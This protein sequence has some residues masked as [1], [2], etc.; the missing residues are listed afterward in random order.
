M[1][2]DNKHILQNTFSLN[3]HS[4]RSIAIITDI[5]LCLI[6]TWFAFFVRLEDY[7]LISNYN[8]NKAVIISLVAIPIFWVSGVYRT[9]FRYAGLSILFTITLST[10][11]YGVVYF[12][13]ITIYEIKG[14]PRIIGILQPI[15]F[16]LLIVASR[17]TAKFLLTGTF[18][19]LGNIKN[20]ENILIY[21][22]GDI[23]R[24]L[25]ISLE[26]N[27]QYKVVGFLDDN[28]Q[29]HRQ[30]LLG[31]KIYD[32]NKIENLK[33]NKNINLILFAIPSINRSKKNEIIKNLL[34][35]QLVVKT[36][37]YLNDIIDGKVSVSD[38]KDFLV[39]DLLFRDQIEPDQD[40]LNKNIKSK[41]VLVTGAGGTIGAELCR[42]II[43]L[44]PKILILLEFNEFAL[45]KI[46]DELISINKNLKIIPLLS[47]VQDQ[48]K[49][50][51]IFQTFKVDTIYHT[52]A[53]KHV[54]LVEAN[55]CEG[56]K[57]NVFGTLAVAKASINQK[58]KNLVLISS[59]KAV[60]PT[61][62][63][64]ASKRFAEL[65]MQGLH[66]MNK[67][68]GTSFSIVRFGN[69]I[70]SSGSAIPKF[71]K[72]IK[73]GGPIT[74]THP[75]VTRYFMTVTE[76]AQLVIQA[77]AMSDDCE[78]FILDMGESVKIKNLINKMIVLSGL[79]VKDDKNLDGDI[80][81]NVTG[82]RP[83]EKLY[84][85]LL[86]GDNPEKTS[87]LKIQKIK[88]PTI[89]YDKLKIALNDL[90]IFLNNN[91]TNEVKKLLDKLVKL[92]TSN[93]KIVD[94]IYKEQIRNDNKKKSIHDKNQI[95]NVVKIK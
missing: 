35:H 87:H 94:H 47:N 12:S 19:Q 46:K 15:L 63:M 42:Q 64:G 24:Q 17:F 85:E 27:P 80:E 8:F 66:N 21:G 2:S 29:L 60:R 84:E 81:I 1:K 88:E 16:F 38:I 23:G 30:I 40:L 61:N 9:L 57:N 62:I 54:D 45:Y 95:N 26:N 6:S 91:E 32:P 13:I 83:G 82:L 67:D 48:Q 20:K 79:K 22:A 33:Q 52:A 53:Y 51:K 72:Q 77:G 10:L 44:K 76:A 58:V 28:P 25:L 36:L 37:P 73:Y 3:R 41:S 75:D 56:V 89:P 70:N 90:A 69:V 31:Q 92:Y 7:N 68:I 43:R 18:K 86:I 14:V 39:D 65:C 59:D 93:S 11:A 50:E 49:L 74:L 55:I 34:N 4:K 78:V 5:L 71:R